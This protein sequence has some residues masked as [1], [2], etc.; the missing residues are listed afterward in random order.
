[1]T[2]AL[3]SSPDTRV[4]RVE[5]SRRGCGRCRRCRRRR[6]RHHP[7][8]NCRQNDDHRDQGEESKLVSIKR[9][10]IMPPSA[11]QPAATSKS[12]LF[13]SVF[14]LLT[15]NLH[16]F[17]AATCAAVVVVASESRPARETSMGAQLVVEDLRGFLVSIAND[18]HSATTSI[19]CHCVVQQQRRLRPSSRWCK[20]QPARGE[21]E[22]EREEREE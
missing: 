13:A 2:T 10:L 3:P 12:C 5:S 1:M 7:S 9:V 15:H 6:R 11:L 18:E 14:A 4:L 20:L 21:G 19:V 17:R 16:R 8:P 22:R